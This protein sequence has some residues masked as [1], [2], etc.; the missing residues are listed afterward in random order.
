MRCAD[1]SGLTA[2]GRPRREDVRRQEWTLRRIPKILRVST[3][4]VYQLRRAWWAGGDVTLVSKGP[5]G[6]GCKPVEQQSTWLRVGLDPGRLPMDG[7]P[8]SGGRWPGSSC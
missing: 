5:A 2:E 4:S 8:I 6:F 3:K 1:G 7:T